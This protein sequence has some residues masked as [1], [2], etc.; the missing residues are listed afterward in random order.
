MVAEAWVAIKRICVGV[1]RVREANTQQL[2]REFNA[3]V[4]KEVE[5]AEDFANCITGLA[6]DLR[7]LGDNVTDTEVVRKMLQVMP[8][9][10]AQVAISI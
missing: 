1:Q 2:W 3:L 5:T 6:A 9:H 7:L 4:W 10:L 8:E